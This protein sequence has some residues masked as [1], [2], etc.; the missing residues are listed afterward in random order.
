[1]RRQRLRWR[2]VQRWLRGPNGWR[3]IVL[4]GIELFNIASVRVTRYRRRDSNIPC[5][6]PPQAIDQLA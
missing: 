1:M 5:P 6:W 3:P 4:D 2:D